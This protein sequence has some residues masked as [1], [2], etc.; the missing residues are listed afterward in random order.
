MSQL[1][2]SPINAGGLSSPDLNHGPVQC[3]HSFRSAV[4]SS[5]VNCVLRQQ[6][7][8][9]EFQHR[10]NFIL[11]RDLIVFNPLTDA[12]RLLNPLKCRGV[13]WLH[14]AIQV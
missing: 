6:S 13:N 14:T 5:V 9:M 4:P 12:A 8:L 7:M 1:T 11:R 2:N 10:F 3:L